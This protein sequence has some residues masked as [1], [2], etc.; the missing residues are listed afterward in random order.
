M[1]LESE[2]TP[3]YVD[4]GEDLSIEIF[5]ILSEFAN[6]LEQSTKVYRAQGLVLTDKSLLPV[7]AD[8]LRRCREIK[9]K[10]LTQTEIQ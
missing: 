7:P 1:S 4:L 2:K 3:A 9:N 10:L 8:V 6:Y 5:A